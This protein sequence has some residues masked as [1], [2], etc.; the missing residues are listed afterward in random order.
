MMVKAITERIARAC[1]AHPRR[2]LVGWAVAVVVALVLVATSLHGL[3]SNAH[4]V[5]SPE[6]TKAANA[7]ATAFPPT[8]ADL[9]RQVS[10]VVVI[11]SR[12]YA[13]DTPQFR[14]LVSRLVE[15]LRTAGK[16]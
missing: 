1:G 11:S 7:I 5:G 12:R 4:V 9:K 2:T 8:P 14:S 15:Q 6:S 16:V 3:T 10:D 13:V